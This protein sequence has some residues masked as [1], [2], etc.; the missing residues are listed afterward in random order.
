[1][2]EQ[3][4]AMGKPCPQPVI[5]AKKALD[6]MGAGAVEIQVDNETSVANLV[7]F[8][9]NMGAKAEH[10]KEGGA[11]FV[12]IEKEA[13]QKTPAEEEIQCQ[14]LTFGGPV[15]GVGIGSSRMG[16]GSDE[17]GDILMK[18]LLFTI[19]QTEPLPEAVLFF[20]GGVH[21]TTE[22]SPVIDDLK[23][24][25]EQGVQIISCGTCLDYFGI[26]DKLLVGEVSNMYTIYE[27]LR[28]THALLFD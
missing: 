24:M 10:R 19:S 2:T 16:H 27:T 18:S 21:L 22:G 7:K 25:A 17:L 26:K 28:E 23:Q 1:M 15:R 20:N 4:N 8:A 5:L 12:T 13:E 11:Y 3:I 14:P 6:A 9:E